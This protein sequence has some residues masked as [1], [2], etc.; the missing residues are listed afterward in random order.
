MIKAIELS[1]EDMEEMMNN[2]PKHLQ[3]KLKELIGEMECPDSGIHVLKHFLEQ[4]EEDNSMDNIISFTCA[5]MITNITSLAE[6]SIKEFKKNGKK[7]ING[8]DMAYIVIECLKK[9]AEKISRAM[10]HHDKH[11]HKH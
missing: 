3:D 1:R 9:E 8:Q 7:G 2:L 4:F 10:E 11:C 6:K 5:S